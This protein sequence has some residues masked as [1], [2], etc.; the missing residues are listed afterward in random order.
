MPCRKDE[1]PGLF[2]SPCLSKS[3]TGLFLALMPLPDLLLCL[4]RPFPPSKPPA[5]TC[6][7]LGSMVQ[8]QLK[9]TF[10]VFHQPCLLSFSSALP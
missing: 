7:P 4:G 9:H 5:L 2:C 10:L 6:G 3:H 8:T 1:L